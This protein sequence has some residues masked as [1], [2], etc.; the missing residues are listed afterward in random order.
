MADTNKHR[1]AL[2]YT[3]NALYTK[4]CNSAREWLVKDHG[5]QYAC[6]NVSAGVSM[7]FYPESDKSSCYKNHFCALC[8]PGTTNESV[9]IST[10]MDAGNLSLLERRD[11]S[12]CHF[13]P[14]INFYSPYKNLFCKHCNHQFDQQRRSPN[15]HLMTF[16]FPEKFFSKSQE[17]YPIYRNLFTYS[18]YDDK[19][20][21][22][23]SPECK[24]TQAY[25]SEV[26]SLI[27]F[28]CLALN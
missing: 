14:Q 7:E 17:Y 25:I 21:Q 24:S 11:V 3:R 8:N 19:L 28:I 5:V 22:N 12:G 1:T 15:C 26:V 16:K 10:C 2:C 9:T 18:E 6:E 20:P 13:F 27:S 23:E 4:T